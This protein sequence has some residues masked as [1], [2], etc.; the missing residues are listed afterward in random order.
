MVNLK[1]LDLYNNQL[2]NV[3]INFG[4]LNKLRYLDLKGNP[5]QPALQKIVGPCLTTKDCLDAAKQIV[6]FMTDL[7]IKFQAEQS[8]KDE[9]ERKR[10]EAEDA[11][12]REQARLAKKAARKER[13]TRERQEK[14]ETEKLIDEDEPSTNQSQTKLQ[15]SATKAIS[16]TA[17]KSS[18]NI[19]SFLKSLVAISTLLVII[20]VSFLKFLP[21]QSDK[22]LSLLPKQQQNLLRFFFEKI[23]GSVLSI[24]TKVLNLYKM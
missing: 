15:R 7:E 10:R 24:Y 20:L 14:A 16:K 4:K 18:S 1:H 11:E 17:I 12:M 2:E 21:D 13:V 8:K 19:L 22:V 5:L 6:P 3:P 9:E 23:D